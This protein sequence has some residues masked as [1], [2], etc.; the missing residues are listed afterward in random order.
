AILAVYRPSI[1]E[2]LDGAVYDQTL[3]WAGTRRP[4][5]RVVIVDVDER[6]LFK[7]G[8]WP[9]RRDVIARLVA[10]LRDAGASVIALDI[11]FAER[12]RGDQHTDET[13]ADTL[14][15]GRVVLGYG[16]T[17]DAAPPVAQRCALHPFPLVV[18]Q[19]G[20]DTDSAPFFRATGA[21]CSLR[22]LAD[23]AGSSG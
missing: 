14:R 13:L 17:F 22:D 10:R 1:A 19:Q 21:I 7:Y 15:R 3:R 11:I 18:V 5:D 23:A 4:A 9:W 12:D 6:S 20:R 8:Q 2:R 16:F